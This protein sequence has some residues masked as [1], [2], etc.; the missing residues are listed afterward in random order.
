MTKEKEE[1][2]R[3]TEPSR[4]QGCRGPGRA[5]E[6]EGD[7]KTDGAGGAARG[8][9]G[10]EGVSELAS[11]RGWVLRAGEDPLIMQMARVLP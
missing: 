5:P 8:G 9:V 7:R 2:H 4:R 11:F 10:G 1:G 6:L 3:R